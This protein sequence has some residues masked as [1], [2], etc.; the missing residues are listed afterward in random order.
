MEFL[1]INSSLEKITFNELMCDVLM[2]ETI[3]WWKCH[4]PFYE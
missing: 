3:C 2:E 4:N 1:T